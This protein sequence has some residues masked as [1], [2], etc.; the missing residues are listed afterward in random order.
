MS[1]VES[2]SHLVITSSLKVP[3]HIRDALILERSFTSALTKDLTAENVAELFKTTR[4]VTDFDSETMQLALF[5]SS[6][7]S[8]V[9]MQTVVHWVKNLNKLKAVASAIKRLDMAAIVASGDMKTVKS[10]VEAAKFAVIK[11]RFK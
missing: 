10:R 7:R 8:A 2:F 9:F 5:V 3:N 6:M 11:R 1:A 4:F